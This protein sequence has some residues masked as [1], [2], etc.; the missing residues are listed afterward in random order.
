MSVDYGKLYRFSEEFALR[1]RGFRA[2]AESGAIEDPHALLRGEW[3]PRTAIRFHHQ[4]GKRVCDVIWTGFVAVVLVSR[5]FRD[6]LRREG[7]TGW[8]TYPV[9]VYDHEDNELSGYTGLAVTGRAGAVDHSRSKKVWRRRI[10]GGPRLQRYVGM[11]I[12]NDE[13]DGSDLFQMAGRSTKLVTERV[14]EALQAELKIPN[15]EFDQ[16]STFEHDIT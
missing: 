7:F 15:T 2:S 16:L 8:S 13:W 14:K 3:R 6:V 4:A 10:K 9:K 5:R 11:F 1:G 12:E